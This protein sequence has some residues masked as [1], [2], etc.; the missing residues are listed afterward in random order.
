MDSTEECLIA[1]LFPTLACKL[2]YKAFR[3]VGLEV[4]HIV[5]DFAYRVPGKLPQVSS[6]DMWTNDIGS[7]Q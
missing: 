4:N 7:K 2:V 6:E 1:M 5:P 3:Q